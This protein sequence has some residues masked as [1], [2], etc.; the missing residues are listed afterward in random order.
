MEI[1][2]V[3]WM[4]E[5]LSFILRVTL[6]TLKSPGGERAVGGAG[7][8]RDSCYPFYRWGRHIGKGEML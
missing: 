8:S 5:E 6:A 1:T 4:V 2:V 3:R 7:K